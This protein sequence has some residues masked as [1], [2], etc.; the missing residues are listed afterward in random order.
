MELSELLDFPWSYVGS[1]CSRSSLDC[2]LIPTGVWPLAEWAVW[3]E[4]L[5]LLNLNFKLTGLGGLGGGGCWLVPFFTV[6][7]S[8]SISS[9]VKWLLN[10]DDVR[11]LFIC[12]MDTELSSSPLKWL[13]GRLLWLLLLGLLVL[14]CVVTRLG[15]NGRLGLTVSSR[16]I[17]VLAASSSELFD[18][19]ELIESRCELLDAIDNW[20]EL[21]L[22]PT[23]YD[24]NAR[25]E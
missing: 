6:K 10:L 1:P 24:N 20:F 23:K 7:S 12:C 3:L 25:P 15:R 4:P 2:E 13:M 18:F 21:F 17:F 19:I 22:S 14:F 16:T 11:L 8:S 9:W 5:W